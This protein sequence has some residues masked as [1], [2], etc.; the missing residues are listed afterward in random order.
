MFLRSLR[1]FPLANTIAI[2][3]A[4]WMC[5]QVKQEIL[6]NKRREID[7]FRS[8]QL[9][10][11]GESRYFNFVNKFFQTRYTTELHWL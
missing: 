1:F 10:V 2:S 8:I 3:V 6:S 9:Y 11:H 7:R 5:W 4:A